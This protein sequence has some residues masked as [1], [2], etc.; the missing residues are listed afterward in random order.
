[1]P[2]ISS[3]YSSNAGMV[4]LS[5]LMESVLLN[6]KPALLALIMP[7]SLKL[8]PAAMVSKP[9]CCRAR[10]VVSFVCS[11]RILKPVTSPDSVTTSSLQN[12]VGQP[13]FFIR[14]WANWVK[15]S[16][17]MITCVRLRS[18]SRNSLAPGI[19]SMVAITS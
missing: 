19:G 1:M 8:S 11:Q 9:A 17:M 6:R 5:A 4:G 16:L 18:S 3:L 15:V 12:S 13:S 2:A 14:G 10:T 7:R